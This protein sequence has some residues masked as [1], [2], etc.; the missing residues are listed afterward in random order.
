MAI[1]E[2]KVH[3]CRAKLDVER[4]DIDVEM[5]QGWEGGMIGFFIVEGKCLRQ[6]AVDGRGDMT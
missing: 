3:S 2:N 4:L 1:E 5:P 6:V